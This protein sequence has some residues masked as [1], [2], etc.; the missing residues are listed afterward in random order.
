M[1]AEAIAHPAGGLEEWNLGHLGAGAATER[2]PVKITGRAD[3]GG[4]DGASR[5]WIQNSSAK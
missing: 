4:H 2:P 1:P 3:E 5:R